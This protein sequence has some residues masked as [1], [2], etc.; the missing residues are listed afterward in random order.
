M[1]T[2][3]TPIGEIH[4]ES[5]KAIEQNCF[6]IPWDDE[7]FQMLARWQGRILLEGGRLIRMDIAEENGEIGGYIVWEENRVSFKGRIMNIAVKKICRRKGIGRL[8]LI[9]ALKS[10]RENGMTICELEVRENNF[11]AQ[12]LYESVKMKVSDRVPG[13]YETEDAIIYSIRL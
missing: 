1:T 5:V 8:L 2:R 6:P 10:Q 11:S 13:Y 12:R 4:L 7:V 3:I 9:H